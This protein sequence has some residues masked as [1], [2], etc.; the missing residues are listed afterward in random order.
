[1]LLVHFPDNSNIWFARHQN[2]DLH[3]APWPFHRLEDLIPVKKS[4]IRFRFVRQQDGSQAS[5]SIQFPNL[6]L[7]NPLI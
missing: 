4:A 3:S 2:F 6:L 7:F 5:T 1:M